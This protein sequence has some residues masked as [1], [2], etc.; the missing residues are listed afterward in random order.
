[1]K[2]P[3][4]KTPRFYRMLFKGIPFAGGVRWASALCALHQ[5]TLESVTYLARFQLLR[6]LLGRQKPDSQIPFVVVKI[7]PPPTV[8]ALEPMITLR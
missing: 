7:R 1:M 8:E 5:A 4:V 2:T 6:P 3:I